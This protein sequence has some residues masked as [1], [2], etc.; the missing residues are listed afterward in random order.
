MTPLYTPGFILRFKLRHATQVAT[1]RP[2][3]PLSIGPTFHCASRI[4]RR[5]SRQASHRPLFSPAGSRGKLPGR[6]LASFPSA[7]WTTP[8][9]PCSPARARPKSLHSSVPCASGDGLHDFVGWAECFCRGSRVSAL[10]YWGPGDAVTEEGTGNGI[11][12]ST[13]PYCT[14]SPLSEASLSPDSPQSL[15][16]SVLAGTTQAS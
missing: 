3:H 14:S 16:A 9:Q 5:I 7:S 2:P 1:T 4:S 15:C 13:A 6:G 10:W 12:E 8:P 11:V